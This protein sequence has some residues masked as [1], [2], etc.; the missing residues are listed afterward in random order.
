MAC[1]DAVVATVDEVDAVVGSVRAVVEVV[2]TEATAEVVDVELDDVVEEVGIEDDVELVVE[3]ETEVEFPARECEADKEA[4]RDELADDAYPGALRDQNTESSIIIVLWLSAHSDSSTDKEADNEAL[5]AIDDVVVDNVE[6]VVEPETEVEFP[7]RECEADK[8]AD[9]DEL[10]D[11]AATGALRDQNTES[12]MII[13]LWLKAYSDSEADEEADE[14]AL[15]PIDVVGA[16]EE[17]LGT[18]NA[19][20]WAPAIGPTRRPLPAI[21]AAHA[22]AS[23]AAPAAAPPGDRLTNFL[24]CDMVGPPI[25]RRCL[26]GTQREAPCHP[27][28]LRIGRRVA[29]VRAAIAAVQPDQTARHSEWP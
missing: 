25:W 9:R 4:D 24:A 20:V 22:T 14:E 29:T 7:A 17:V 12:S 26:L 28:L 11:D 15:G 8:E 5:G 3:P 27:R 1:V 13:Q 10:A 21:S 6:L 16:T 19:S 23:T 2:E 18:S